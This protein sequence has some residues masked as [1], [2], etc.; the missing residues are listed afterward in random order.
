MTTTPV[1]PWDQRVQ[2]LHPKSDPVFWPD[3]LRVKY[4]AIEISEL[5]AA[6]AAAQAVTVPAS[7]QTP[8]ITDWPPVLQQTLAFVERVT[9]WQEGRPNKNDALIAL[10]AA[11]A[12]PEQLAAVSAVE[13]TIKQSLTVAEQSTELDAGMAAQHYCRGLWGAARGH[14]D[15]R[16]VHDHFSN[17]YK[18]GR[19]D[20]LQ[21]QGP[22]SSI[23]DKYAPVQHEEKK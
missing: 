20:E 22:D 2:A 15:W 17:G 21:A 8:P 9:H 3:E 12:Q 16:K 23:W 1:L 18:Q 6:I 7:S 11:I 10:R 4:M 14:S 13:P 19:H 5:R